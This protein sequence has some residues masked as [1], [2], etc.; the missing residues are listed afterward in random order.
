MPYILPHLGIKLRNKLTFELA[1][2]VSEV[3]LLLS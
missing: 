2:S 1:Y 3:E